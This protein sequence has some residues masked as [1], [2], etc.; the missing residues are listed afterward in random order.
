[1]GRHDH[2]AGCP[3]RSHR[4][5]GAIVEAA[6][7]LAFG[8]LLGLIGGQVQPR[9]NLRMSEQ[10]IVFAARHKRE[11]SHIGEHRPIAILPIKPD[12]RVFL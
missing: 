2:A 9:L 8:A 1:M 6:H 5:P 4:N 10:V 12:Q 3:I 7:R 11:P